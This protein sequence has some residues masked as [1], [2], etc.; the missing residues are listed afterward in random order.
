MKFFVR[1]FALSILIS[2]GAVFALPACRTYVQAQNQPIRIGITSP[3]YDD[4]G[5]IIRGI[6]G[7]FE[8]VTLTN[9]HF[10]N[11]YALS[12][13][14]AIFINCGS[15]NIVNTTTLRS[16]VYQGGIVYASD[17]AGDSLLAAF[18]GL[19]SFSTGDAQ[20]IHNA[21]IVLRSLAMHM[22]RDHLDVIFD[23]S[24]WYVV[25]NLT[26]DA[27]VYIRGNV[28]GHGDR[29]LA[30]SF[31]FGRGR[32][33][34]TSFHNHMQATGDMLNF[35]EYLVFRIQ[36]I[37]AERN[38]AQMAYEEG[39]RFDG[40]V[41]GVLSHNEVSE[42]FYYTP[43]END[44]MLLF[45]PQMGD[46]T[47]FLQAPDGEVFQTGEVGVLSQIDID[48]HD[49]DLA[50]QGF[51][52]ELITDEMIVE[53][54]GHRGFRVLN[55][56]DGS[57]SF[58]VR[59]NNPEPEL[60]FAVGL[61][62]RPTAALTRAMFTQVVANLDRANLAPFRNVPETFNDVT[63]DAWFFEP[64]EWAAHN[65]LVFGVAPDRFSPNTPLSREELAVMMYRYASH[66]GVELPNHGFIPFVD[67]DSISSWAVDEVIRLNSAGIV[68]GRIDGRFDPQTTATTMEISEVFANFIEIIPDW[69]PPEAVEF[70]AAPLPPL[71]E[72][73]N[74][75]A[76][77][78][79]E[80]A[81]DREEP[82]DYEYDS[83]T[84]VMASGFEPGNPSVINGYGT[85]L[86]LGLELWHI[87][88]IAAGFVALI[89]TTGTIMVFRRKKA[90]PIRSAPAIGYGFQ[91]TPTYNPDSLQYA[92]TAPQTPYPNAATPPTYDSPQSM[93]VCTYCGTNVGFG[94]A[95]CPGCGQQVTT[96]QQSVVSKSCNNCSNPFSN[97][98][99][100]FCSVCGT[101]RMV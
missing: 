19:F 64:V 97:D 51:P 24:G 13:F 31:D 21:S 8:F 34:Y 10:A 12:Q 17:L 42:P 60:M 38:L 63:R 46:F 2:L 50:F 49:L 91:A 43:Q 56:L 99:V 1:M 16:Y 82:R 71:P 100:Q 15:H 84:L 95:F 41:F 96:A 83:E 35:I 66:L 98:T 58:W 22:G 36:H 61:A 6:G 33:F 65:E 92:P 80:N 25:S 78:I 55:P 59:S 18:P 86:P 68:P 32:V 73:D 27:T 37:E 69:V 29:P 93:S 62:E 53:G 85:A 90:P 47:I 81:Y 75:D 72:D 54:L 3:S 7:N 67:Q 77:I 87:A 79:Y 57:W 9:A 40:L 20:T 88:L 11:V 26:A 30:F 52:I 94:T 89:G 70:P 5:Q 4:V 76:D 74:G 101:K 48:M 45:D 14:Y 28:A 23:L 44:F 39:Y